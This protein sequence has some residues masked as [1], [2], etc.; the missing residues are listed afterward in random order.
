MNN[1]NDSADKESVLTVID[2]SITFYKI[3][4]VIAASDILMYEFARKHYPDYQPEDGFGYYKLMDKKIEYIQ[5]HRKLI[6]MDK[7]R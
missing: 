4:T 2:L 7:V 3:W 1:S 5:P 6:L